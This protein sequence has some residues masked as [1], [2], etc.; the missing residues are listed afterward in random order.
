V[1]CVC[2]VNTNPC[3]LPPLSVFAGF[4]LKPFGFFAGNPSLDIPA[5]KDQVSKEHLAATSACCSNGSS[6]PGTP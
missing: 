4:V 2:C 6:A 3:L 1:L 5:G